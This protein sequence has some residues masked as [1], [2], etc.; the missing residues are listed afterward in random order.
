MNQDSAYWHARAAALAF[1]GQAY[2]D[3]A[4]C[5][6]ADGAQPRLFLAAL[7]PFFFVVPCPSPPGR[8]FAFTFG[9]NFASSAFRLACSAASARFTYSSGSA[10]SS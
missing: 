4:Y 5:G 6:A 2:I 8:S 1:N 7:F 3:G 10:A 9:K